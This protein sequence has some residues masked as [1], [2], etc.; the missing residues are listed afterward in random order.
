MADQTQLDDANR[1]AAVMLE[2]LQEAVMAVQQGRSQDETLRWLVE[3][4]RSLTGSR[5]AAMGVRD[6]R[7]GQLSAFVHSGMSAEVVRRIP[8]LP[9]GRGL[10]GAVLHE[11]QPIRVPDLSRDPRSSGVPAGHPPMTTF[12]G[13]PIFVGGEVYGNFYLCDKENGQEYTADD[14]HLI[15]LLAA[16]AALMIAYARQVRINEEQR[17]TLEAV[18]REAPDGIMFFD[19]DGLL[20]LGNP[21]AERIF[22]RRLTAVPS[23][24]RPAS[25]GMQTPDGRPLD[26]ARLPVERALAGEQP[27][28]E[29]LIA[30]PDGTRLEV[31]LNAARVTIGDRLIGVV[32]VVQDISAYKEL[33]RMREE[34]AA[35]V[36]HDLRNPIQALLLGIDTLLRRAEDGQ[37]T[38][39]VARLDRMQ[40]TAVRL[41]R[42]VGDLL[43]SSRL[44]L[45]RVRIDRRVLS[46]PDATANLVGNMRPTVGDH[47]VLYRV[48]GAPRDVLADPFRVDQILTNLLENAAR[49]SPAGA[50]IEVTVSEHGEGAM[51]AVRDHGPGISAED[52]PRIFERYFQA[53]RAREERTGL[54]L[55]LYITR[56]LVEAQ[57]GRIRVESTPGNGST[58]FVWFPEAAQPAGEA[59]P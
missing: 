54:G 42:L 49:Y 6:P 8:H 34:M 17:L 33:G 40:H 43:E 24:Q 19:G 13:V 20:L 1:R 7:T 48:E 29:I 25:W 51:V 9:E 11:R 12:L 35:V 2:S 39:P 21:A 53:R 10:L 14:E 18:L 50:P 55:G 56:S 3:Q 26:P 36:A 45:G 59:S 37:V 58:F 30:R 5:Y 27:R 52:L 31:S 57:G 44:E 41:A 22:G 4:A 16:Q 28:E 15:V 47:E 23:A 46:L 32:V 38:V